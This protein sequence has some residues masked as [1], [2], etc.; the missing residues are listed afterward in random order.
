LKTLLQSATKDQV[1]DAIRPIANR[2]KAPV[3]TECDA[4]DFKSKGTNSFS[5]GQFAASLGFF[6]QALACK[7]SVDLVKLAYTAAC[8]ARNATKAKLYFQRLSSQVQKDVQVICIRNMIQV[9]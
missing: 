9:P 6:E 1:A 2:C 7:P 3:A 8:N 4:E 5:M